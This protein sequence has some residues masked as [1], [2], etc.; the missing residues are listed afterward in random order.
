MSDVATTNLPPIE[1]F[2]TFWRRTHKYSIGGFFFVG[3]IMKSGIYCISNLVNGKKYIGQSITAQY[4]ANKHIAF[5]LRG[6]HINSH[7]QRSFLKHGE[8][9]FVTSVLEF[10]KEC[11]LDDREKWW[12]S[13]H[14][15]SCRN[16]GFN[17]EEGG[18]LN[19]RCSK[20]TREKLSEIGKRYVFTETHKRNISESKKNISQETRLKLSLANKKR[21]PEDFK[22]LAQYNIGRKISEETR[23][24]MSESHKGKRLS[25]E[26]RQKMSISQIKRQNAIGRWLE[27]QLPGLDDEKQPI[28]AVQNAPQSHKAGK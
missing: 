19:K 23:K 8:K 13:F 17:I 15:S 26:T 24:K 7:M 10:C 21:N 16:H 11:D 27:S 9:C 2:D 4:R 1:E 12:I 20:E 28:Q 14:K 18:S 22:R 6:N 5:L 25:L 3:E